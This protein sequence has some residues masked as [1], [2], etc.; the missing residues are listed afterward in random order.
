MKKYIKYIINV[1][2]ILFT[3][4]FILHTPSYADSI[5]SSININNLDMNSIN[6]NNVDDFKNAIQ[7][8]K[9]NE[10]L[11]NKVSSGN[12]D[13]SDIIDAYKELSTVVSN[14]ELANFIEDNKNEIAKQGISKSALSTASTLLKTFDSNAVID[15][16]ENDLNVDETIKSTDANGEAISTSEIVEQVLD[17]TSSADKIKIA[18]KLLFS[19]ENFR[20]LII[21]GIVILA[22]S[23]YI[24]GLIFKKADKPSFATV[25]PIYR[26][27]IHL[28]ICNFSPWVLILVF[29]PVIGWL[30]LL[31]IAIIRKIRTF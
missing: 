7:N 12:A 25:I 22:Y 14:K 26:D 28:K 15:V 21:A 1:A 11:A 24:T 10:E 19:N 30:A 23:V 13:L 31:A 9:E 18:L 20:L 29:I 27:I 5:F 2:F 3:I 4:L 6:V 8:I 16:L 17:N